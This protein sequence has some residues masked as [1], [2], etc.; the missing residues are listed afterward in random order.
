M[1]DSVISIEKNTIDVSIAIYSNDREFDYRFLVKGHPDLEGVVSLEYQELE[2]GYSEKDYI[3]K[4]SLSFNKEDWHK[5][6]Y[7]VETFF[8]KNI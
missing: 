2:G 4:N 8:E 7:A 1:S 3:T 5:I 6:Q